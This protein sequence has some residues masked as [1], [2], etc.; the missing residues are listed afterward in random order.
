MI[1]KAH[2]MQVLPGQMPL[3]VVG[4]RSSCISNRS[5]SDNSNRSG[6][7]IWMCIDKSLYYK[8]VFK[9]HQKRMTY[10]IICY[11]PVDYNGGLLI[12]Y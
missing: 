1:A 2:M 12:A 11:I 4:P 9:Y 6:T 7:N 3:V 8:Y 5:N 10:C